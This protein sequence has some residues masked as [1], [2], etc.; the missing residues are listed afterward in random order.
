MKISGRTL[1]CFHIYFVL[2]QGFL[3][4]LVSNFEESD[5]ILHFNEHNDSTCDFTS[6]RSENIKSNRTIFSEML[7]KLRFGP[8]TPY[9]TIVFTKSLCLFDILHMIY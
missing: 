9:F 7:K 5:H 8:M 3:D 6:R 1:K 4:I 2:T